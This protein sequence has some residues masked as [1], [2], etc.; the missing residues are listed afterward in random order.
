MRF[1]HLSDVHV[2]QDYFRVPFRKL[3]W[4]RAIALLE[5]SIGGRAKRYAGARETISRILEERHQH[6]VDH[7]ILSGDL[8]AYAT[9]WEFEQARQAIGALG[10]DRSKITIIP[11]NH[12]VYT[13]GAYNTRRFE[14]YFGH[15]LHSDLPEYCRDGAF[16]FVRLLGDEVAVVG[17]MSA[18]VPPMPGFSFGVVGRKQLTALRD[19]VHDERLAH[20]AILVVVHH[21]PIAPSGRKDRFLH[22]LMD[23]DLL[24]KILPGPRF[25]VLHGHIHKRYHH[26]ATDKRP[27]TFGAGS[28]T[29]GGH[30][31]YWVIDVR[32]GRIAGGVMHTPRLGE[33]VGAAVEEGAGVVET[34]P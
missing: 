23:A 12:D 5:L 18:R 28:S 29:E 4:R 27:H 7:V 26:A 15:L 19:L 11:G 25:A 31:G 2:T 3:G 20:R 13:P 21:A 30:E 34:H 6:G 17:L 22:G 24:F 32:D 8:T 14:R 33:P 16:P 9:E 10:E 1:L